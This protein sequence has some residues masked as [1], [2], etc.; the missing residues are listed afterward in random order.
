ML[1]VGCKGVILFKLF[2]VVKFSVFCRENGKRLPRCC[3]RY[4]SGSFMHASFWCL[5]Q[6][7]FRN[8]L[9]GIVSRFIVAN[10]F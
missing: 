5:I 10:F 3:N 8:E 1:F 7:H 9:R 6:A 4:S 2:R